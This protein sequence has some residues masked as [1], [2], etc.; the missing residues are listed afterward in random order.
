MMSAK[1]V[2]KRCPRCGYH[3]LRAYFKYHVCRPGDVF[4][5]YQETALERAQKGKR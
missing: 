4:T 2:V 5:I 3:Q 1:P